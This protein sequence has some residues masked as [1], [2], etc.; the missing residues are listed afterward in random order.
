M[1]KILL[2]TV[3]GSFQPI[4]TAIH[5]L[6]PDR[7]IFIASDGEKGSKSQVIG[8]GTPCEVRR[9]AEVIERL[10]NIPT[11]VNLGENFQP[12]R[13]L[14]LV[15]NP[16]NLAECYSKICNCIRKLQQESGHQ[17]MADY[18]G[19]TKTLSAA[20][21]MAAVDCGISLYITIAARDNLVKVERGELTQKVDTSFK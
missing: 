20:L 6:Q 1:S 13:D 9:G 10:P 19:G 7:V 18:T 11:Q 12:E 4:I 14:I 2:V 8:E 3:G 5:S 21:V 16:D 17:I 15:Q